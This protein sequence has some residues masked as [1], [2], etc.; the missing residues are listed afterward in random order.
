MLALFFV[1][2]DLDPKIICRLMVDHVYVKF[3]DPSCIVWINR[4][5][6]KQH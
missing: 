6:Q 4:Q 5:A 1:P 2:C 3:V